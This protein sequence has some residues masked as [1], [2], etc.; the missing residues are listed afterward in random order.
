MPG[1]GYPEKRRVT[2][3]IGFGR[4]RSAVW[5]IL[6]G[7]IDLVLDCLAVS[8]MDLPPKLQIDD[9]DQQLPCGDSLWRAKTAH[10]WEAFQSTSE[11]RNTNLSTLLTGY[12]SSEVDPSHISEF[13]SLLL[14]ASFWV[15]E[16]KALKGSKAFSMLHG[17]RDN[18]AKLNLS[19]DRNLDEKFTRLQPLQPQ[20]LNPSRTDSHAMQARTALYHILFIL[21]HTS[22]KS[23]HTFFG[24]CA[25]PSEIAQTRQ[26][27]SQWVQLNWKTS[28]LCVYH[29]AMAFCHI[30]QATAEAFDCQ[31]LIS[32]VVAVQY[33]R[34]YQH[35]H[36]SASG[37]ANNGHDGTTRVIR[38]DPT[39]NQTKA[40]ESDLIAEW[41]SGQEEVRFY[42]PG[43]GLLLDPR[44]PGCL[45]KECQRLLDSR[46]AV[47]WP[48]F[49]AALCRNLEEIL[50]DVVPLSQPSY[51]VPVDAE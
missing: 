13:S 34:I 42:L 39:S 19:S 24:W 40:D 23:L 45:L 3:E 15:E 14:L 31:H 5:Y 48:I 28:R 20:S 22:L 1:A 44:S 47:G 43:V 27:L 16:R 25:S 2:G 11:A 50:N 17:N 30:R 7:P 29:A 49:R 51:S 38:L 33:L 10:E 21:R 9:I 37:N 32:L 8:L 36:I 46:R 12:C 35:V 41:I 26:S 6:L 18:P 4:R